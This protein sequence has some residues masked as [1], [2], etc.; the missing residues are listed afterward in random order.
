MKFGDLLTGT[1][2]ELDEK[3]RG[4][5]TYTMPNPQ[6]GTRRVIV[7]FATVGDIV[8]VKFV[9]RDGGAWITDLIRVHTPS[10]DRVETTCPHAGVCGGCLW[11]HMS[12]DSQ[13]RVKQEGINRALERA[14]H[15][16]RITGIAPSPDILHY[17]N[18]MD[19][20]FG[21]KGELGLKKYGSW[22]QYIDL[23]TCFL[24]DETTPIIL[25]RLREVLTQ[26][27]L[28][29][30]DAKKHTGD[31]R[32]LVIRE[33]KN[34]NERMIMLVVK[35]KMR[36]TTDMRTKM[37]SALQNLC[38]SFFVGENALITDLSYVQTYDVLLGEPFLTEHVN[39]C[40][41]RIH[42]NSFFQTN[43]KM[44][45][46]LQNAVLES[47]PSGTQ[48]I[49]D[50]YCGLGFFGIAAAKRGVQVY[51]HELDAHAIEL[52]RVN[53]ELNNVAD[54]CSFGAGPVEELDWSGMNANTVI[55]DPPRSGLHPRALQTLL[56]NAPKRIIY[57]SCQYHNFVKELTLLKEKYRVE[58]VRAF[59]LFPQT[60]HVE[61]LTV[62]DRK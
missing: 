45:G 28:V 57:V 9:K 42:P 47:I 39:E 5:F 36:V 17:R 1:I 48:K 12:Y 60:P 56:A 25:K 52:A 58:S 13:L 20:V 24:L 8:E 34:T 14:G 40:T 11:Q 21:W 38:T 49:L 35:D 29:P 22:S 15:S 62:L 16:E 2:T 31:L 27:D 7:P 59:D 23:S 44:A 3:G 30:W 26:T 53:A 18:R 50:L 19:Y 10:P 41:Y 37:C 61:L 46:V 33:G 4:V 6:D 51:G 55:V 32:Y 54:L 43:T